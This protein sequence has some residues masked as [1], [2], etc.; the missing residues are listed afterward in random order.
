MTLGDIIAKFRKDHG[1][2]MDKFSEMAGISKAYISMLERNRTQR[3]E[4]PSPSIETYRNVANAVGMD[5]D[6]LIR[7]V[8]G[9]IRLMPPSPS[10]ADKVVTFRINADIAAGYDQPAQPLADWEGASIDLPESVLHGR[11][12]SDYF[13][14]RICG[15]SMYPHYHDGD[16]VLVLKQATLNRSGE[17]G[18]LLNGDEGTLKKIEYVHGEDWLK[19]IPLN[20]EYE[21]RTISGADLEQCRVIGI[22]KL[23]IRNL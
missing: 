12:Q 4:E 21:P 1:L 2:S 3:G 20:P 10:I 18:V 16:Y 14:I 7:M 19:L 8:D 9:K 13:V 11:P 5:T 15:N 17:V 23:L 6:E 22:P